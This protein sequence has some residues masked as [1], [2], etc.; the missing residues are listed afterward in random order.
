MILFLMRGLLLRFGILAGALTLLASCTTSTL[1]PQ[2]Q[3][4]RGLTPQRVD[5]YVGNKAA[6]PY[7]R[8]T[9]AELLGTPAQSL[10]RYVTIETNILEFKNPTLG[11]ELENKWGQAKTEGFAVAHFGDS[12]VHG[13]FAAEMARGRLQTFG[14]SAGR[15]MTFPYAIAKT[16][17]Q[18]DF[19][20]T[21]TGE[22]IS[23]NSA[24]PSPRLPLGVSGFAARTSDASA[25]FSLNFYTV[26]ELGKKRVKVF[27]STNSANYTLRV[28]SA[29]FLHR[30]NLPNGGA[31]PRT[32]M[33]ELSFPEMS[34]ALRFELTSVGPNSGRFFEVHG[35]SIENTTPG[36]LYHSLGVGS[37]NYGALLGQTYFEEQSAQ[38]APALIV[39]D[40][41]TNDIYSK[42]S[43]P[44]ELEKNMVQTIKRV[45][46]QH[47]KALI[48]LTSAQDMTSRRRNITA[49]WDFATLA[50]R[51]AFENDCLF[52]DWYRIAGGRA[53]MAT[54][55]AYGL[56]GPDHIHL[57]GLGHAVKG[58][59][60]AQAILNTLER[61]KSDP[62]LKSIEIKTTVATQP[63]SVV[64]WLKE[65]SAVPRKG[66]FDKRP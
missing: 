54:W 23:A 10:I 45:R 60:F 33:L 6:K 7:T 52:Y 55:V 34:D 48:I 28:Q 39:L 9:S 14:G 50:R 56:T 20:S 25:S 31:Q 24:Q 61:V 18:N 35:I 63:H 2:D 21:F 8:R 4:D 49:T 36:V 62:T 53:S 59:L 46:A 57:T 27:Y 42:N 51:L 47:P 37:A 26:P 64:G 5:A 22:W 65:V 29:N 16:Y 19:K 43:I 32:Q 41:G 58:E 3:A 12:L 44:L 40:W 15:G 30:V 17:S 13:G 38:L 66:L 11:Q 1:A